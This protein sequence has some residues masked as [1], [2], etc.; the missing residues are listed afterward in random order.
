MTP[1]VAMTAHAMSGDREK[2]LAAGMNDYVAKPISRSALVKMLERW[3]PLRQEKCAP[4]ANSHSTPAARGAQ[5]RAAGMEVPPFVEATWDESH[6]LR[7]LEGDRDMADE[8]IAEFLE[9]TSRELAF[10]EGALAAGD[11]GA[12]NLHAHT[13]KGSAANVG[14]TVLRSVAFDVEKAARAGDMHDAASFAVSLER[15]FEHLK[16]AMLNR[17]G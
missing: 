12:V 15:E 11:I 6:L 3:L 2:C 17:Q 1:V 8:V 9:D 5:I 7:L 13:I 4:E 16:Q 14:G 10:L